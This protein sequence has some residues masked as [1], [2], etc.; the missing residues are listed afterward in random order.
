MTRLVR[1][2]SMTFVF[3]MAMLPAGASGSTGDIVSRAN[4]EAAPDCTSIGLP[5]CPGF[6]VVTPNV[7][8]DPGQSIAYCYYFDTPNLATIGI[9]R[10]SVL[11]GPA[12]AQVIAY[13]TYD[14]NHQ[15]ADRQ[16]PGTMSSVNCGWDPHSFRYFQ[17]HAA[18]EAL[19]MPTDDGAGNPL[20][21][22]LLAGQPAFIEIYFVNPDVTPVDSSVTLFANGWSAAA[23]TRTATYMT[24]NTQIAIPPMS[25]GTPETDSCP[26]PAA[27]TFWWFSSHTHKHAIDATLSNGAATLLSSS[28]WQSPAIATYAAPTF[29]TFGATDKLTYSCTYDNP[30][31]SLIVSGEDFDA[32]EN[33]VGIGYFF[34]AT[35]PQYC[36]NNLGPLGP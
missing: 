29:Y 32:N 11:F 2:G 24:Y 14:T 9:G 7:Q 34:P 19:R 20:A 12:V 25:S 6:T 31:P 8:I 26:V 1:S 3:V 36:V 5:D 35:A 16:P 27:A 13:T 28:D 15:P 33:C 30:T 10:F 4:F 22:E 17:A 21:V 23:Y 18:N